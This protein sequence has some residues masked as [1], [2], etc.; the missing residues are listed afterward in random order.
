[1]VPAPVTVQVDPAHATVR[2][3]GSGVGRVVKDNAVAPVHVKVTVPAAAAVNVAAPVAAGAV[4]TTPLPV[5]V[6]HAQFPTVKHYT[7]K[8]LSSGLI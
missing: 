5:P 4:A 8:G 7:K 2:P 6:L 3:V 1:M